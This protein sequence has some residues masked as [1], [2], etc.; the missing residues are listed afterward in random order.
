MME[1][2]LLLATMAQRFRMTLV[3]NRKVKLLPS[4]TLRPRNG[5]Q[6]VLHERRREAPVRGAAD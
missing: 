2:I 6:M 3:P 5:I 4:V 1:A